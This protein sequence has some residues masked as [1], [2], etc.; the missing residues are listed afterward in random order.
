MTDLSR[1]VEGA[2]AE[3]LLS[4]VRAVGLAFA[5]PALV[6]TPF[7][8]NDLV[9]GLAW[10]LLGILM[11]GTVAIWLLSQ[12]VH[13]RLARSRLTFW[14][15]AFDTAV[16][17]G[18]V[19][20]FSFEIPNVTWALLIALPFDGA[21]RYGWRGAALV[22]VVAEAVFVVHSHLREV[23]SG[24]A[25]NASAHF[26]VFSLLAMV[27][28]I[29]G[30][31][32]E[33]WRRQSARYREQAEELDRA[34]RIRDRLMA[35]TSHE[36]RGSLAAIGSTAELLKDERHRLS[37]DR[38]DRMLAA[39]CRQAE[40]LLVLV[41]DLLVTGRGDDRGL[42]L[43]PVWG[44]LES[45]VTLAIAAAE[46]SRS[47]HEVDVSRVDPIWCELDHQR[48]QQ[49]IRNLVENAFKYSLAGTTVTVTTA[50]TAH[51]VLLTVADEGS[52]IPADQQEELFEP[53]RRGHNASSTQ[54]VGL[55]L[56]VVSRIVSAGGGTVEV[57]SEPGDTEFRV[58][59]PCRTEP[60]GT[61][62][63][64]AQRRTGE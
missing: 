59:L 24:V 22:A 64:P 32:V 51:G 26:F 27:A 30:V 11:V 19:L 14:A 12:R 49:V 41:D 58:S 57:D 7:W 6:T 45:T 46:R 33:V 31:L 16:V 52:G 53:F 55:G 56:Y 35:V 20:I 9:Q 34:H 18:F 62:L 39:T 15:L 17:S 47:G 21:L 4:A 25:V 44:D 36:I 60:V 3:R 29:T 1:G 2:A 43:N 8:P 5:L 10:V 42:E 48:V 40:H 28:G 23:L 63:A 54:G 13:E 50:R 38:V 61:D 37:P